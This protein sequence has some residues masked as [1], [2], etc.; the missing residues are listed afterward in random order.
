[1]ITEMTPIYISLPG[2]SVISYPIHLCQYLIRLNHVIKVCLGL[3]SVSRLSEFGEISVVEEIYRIQ[4]Y[5]VTSL[6]F[7]KPDSHHNL[8][9]VS[10]EGMGF[11][12]MTTCV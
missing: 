8:S 5:L 9:V 10:M 12:P 6:Q 11:E 3:S 4:D 2:I 7:T 1:M